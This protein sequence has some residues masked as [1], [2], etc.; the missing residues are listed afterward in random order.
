M[1]SRTAHREIKQHCRVY[2][3]V[4]MKRRPNI[5]LINPP[6][7]YYQL[8][9]GFNVYFPIGLLSIAASI[10]ELSN[11]RILD[12]LVV[13]FQVDKTDTHVTYGT[14]YSGIQK[15]IR[16]FKPDLIGISIPFSAQSQTAIHI[17]RMAK[18]LCPE[19]CIVFGGPH[20]SVRYKELLENDTCDFCVVGEGEMA[21]RTLIERLISGLDVSDILGISFKREGRIVFNKPHFLENLD[22]LPLPAYDLIDVDDYLNNTNLYKSR[23]IIRE[24]S[25]SMITSR[26]CPYDCI[27]CSIKCHM[28]RNFRYHSPEY[29]IRHL[30]YCIESLNI[31]RFH[32]EDDNISLNRERFETILDMMNDRQMNIEWDTPNGIRADTLDNDILKKIKASG[33]VSLQFAIES[34]NQQVLDQVIKKKTSL[35]YVIDVI[36]QCRELEITTCAF[37]VIGFPGET[38]GKI[39]QT[40]NLALDLFR[41]YQVFPILLFATPLYGTELYDQCIENGLIDGELL[42][43]DFSNATQFYG[44]PL[45][46]T[47]EFSR[48]DLKRLALEFEEKMNRILTKGSLRMMLND[49]KSFLS[50][51]M[52]NRA[53]ETTMYSPS[54][55][56]IDCRG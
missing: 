1:T 32:F 52:R 50:L 20:P 46:E 15:I 38:L 49:K 29:V 53:K 25:I 40:M 37:Y 39:R 33:C 21:F 48:R 55:P 51:E 12:C 19:T 28:G 30:E 11:V 17:S 6:Q 35:N 5:L 14:S 56:H 27:F 36:K 22:D 16:D 4:K 2:L 34:G 47:R 44:S 3:T 41:S 31:R 26:G 13:D 18:E 8:S 42:D 54:I 24:R 23:S 45:I 10:R 7:K 43:E 9:L